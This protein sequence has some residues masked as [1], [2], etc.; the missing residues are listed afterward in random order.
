MADQ[1]RARRGSGTVSYD[2]DRKR[3]VGRIYIDG[4][5]RKVY[6][7][8]KTDAAARMTEL[9]KAPIAE[10][11]ARVRKPKITVSAVVKDFLERDLAGRGRAPSTV[12][13]HEW[14]AGH[15]RAEL[16]HHDATKLRVRD[17]DD[18]LDR[19][20]EQG[21]SRSALL[22][23]RGTLS[24]SLR[25]AVKRE[26]LDRN[27]A[28]NATIPA[29]APRTRER[30]ALSPDDARAMLEALRGARNGT[31]F[32][33]SLRLGLRPGEA[34]GLHWSDIGVDAV[35]VTR[36]VQRD[37]GRTKVV[38]DLKTEKAKRT[39]RLTPDLVERLAEHRAAQVAERLAA[40]SWID[41]SLVFTTPTGNVT[42]PSKNRRQLTAICASITA[43]RREADPKA[44][45]FP[46]ISP[47]EL[48]H[49]CASLL[50]D[51]G[52][53]NELIADLLGHTTTEMVDQTYRHRLRPVVSVAA[54]S[55]WAAG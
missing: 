53:M 34:A 43:T 19:L 27:V 9:L 33:L 4:K 21:L 10:L 2:T 48:R 52:V 25:Y 28:E 18:M 14:A 39:I 7:Q 22:K 40:P 55:D 37:N 44:P 32:A 17:I 31:M 29:S 49:A 26:D 42:D 20:A 46:K 50:S 8:T 11:G 16:G 13:L 51:M 24:Q 30:T 1:R 3:W 6:A 47:N 12:G 36:G 54:D 15:I 23:V 45:P 35:N 38:D 5:R 41:E